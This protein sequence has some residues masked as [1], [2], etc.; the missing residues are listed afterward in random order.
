MLSKFNLYRYVLAGRPAAIVSDVPGT[1]RDAVEV[2]LELGG[3]KVGWVL[4]PKVL[5]TYK[6]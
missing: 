6:L 4:K 2:P 1:T 3:Y 5:F